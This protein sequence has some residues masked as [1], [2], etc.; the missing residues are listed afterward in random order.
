MAEDSD[1]ETVSV[2][3]AVLAQAR[4]IS[5]SSA[6]RLIR[7]RGWPKTSGMMAKSE[8][9]FRVHGWN[10]RETVPGTLP[11]PLPGTIRETV[12]G[13][14][15]R[16]VSPDIHQTTGAFAAAWMAESMR[17]GGRK[18]GCMRPRARRRPDQW[19]R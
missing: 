5:I 12:P 2:T 16:D 8:C 11:P 15:R 4:G 3:K 18:R 1:G 14:G 10:V 6:E 13:T 7:R 19:L 9:R 17:I